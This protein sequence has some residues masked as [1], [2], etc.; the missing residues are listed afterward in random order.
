[1]NSNDVLL[2]VLTGTDNEHQPKPRLNQISSG[3]PAR[4]NWTI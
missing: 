2:P 1:M 4:E 3:D